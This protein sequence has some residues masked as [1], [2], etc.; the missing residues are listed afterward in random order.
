M[1]GGKLFSETKRSNPRWRG[2]IKGGGKLSALAEMK[3]SNCRERGACR[4]MGALGCGR[5]QMARR[6]H[7]WSGAIPVEKEQSK[8]DGSDQ[9]WRGG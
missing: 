9:R 7:K 2:A 1:G 5:G 6:D 3:G 8:V 4:W